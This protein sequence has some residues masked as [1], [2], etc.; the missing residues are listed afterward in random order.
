M[1]QDAFSFSAAFTGLIFRTF[2]YLNP[3][4]ITYETKK[5][6]NYSRNKETA[7]RTEIP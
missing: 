2:Y 7:G 5:A 6:E 3:R 1:A 4:Y